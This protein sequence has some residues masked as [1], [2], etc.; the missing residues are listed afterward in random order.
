MKNL[1]ELK[2]LCEAATPGPWTWECDGDDDPA[3]SFALFAPHIPRLPERLVLHQ[4]NGYIRTTQ[5]N[6]DFIAAA[7]TAMP[8]LIAEVERLQDAYS[9][10]SRD[11]MLMAN[12]KGYGEDDDTGLAE[13][14]TRLEQIIEERES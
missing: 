13:R 12:E 8:E 3:C 6:A 5:P 14:V 4:H 10:V 7:R 1:D 9:R 2:A 11:L